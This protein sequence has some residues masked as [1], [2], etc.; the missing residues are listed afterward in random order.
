MKNPIPD[1]ALD[2]RLGFVGVS[3]SGKTYCTGTC[4]ERLLRRKARVRP[5]QALVVFAV[6]HIGT[7][8]MGLAAVAV[9]V[10][11]WHHFGPGGHHRFDHHRYGGPAASPATPPATPNS[12]TKEG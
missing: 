5:R 7:I 9:L 2:D 6:T 10:V 8:L 4:V 1:A 11:A 3:G 12:T